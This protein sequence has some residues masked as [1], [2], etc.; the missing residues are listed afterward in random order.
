[1]AMRSVPIHDADGNVIGRACYR[2]NG[3][4]CQTTGCTGA[5]TVLCDFP[6]TRRG[7]EATCNRR[8]C[9]SCAVSIGKGQDFCPPHARVAEQGYAPLVTVCIACLSASCAHRE[10]GYVCARRDE[11]TKVIT[12]AQWKAQLSFG[13][14]R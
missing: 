8:V 13:V 11:G 14:I 4:R 2:G 9:R 6:V 3:P 1:M 5:G 10:D 12:V 7:R